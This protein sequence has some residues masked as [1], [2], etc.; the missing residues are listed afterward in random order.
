MAIPLRV[1]IVEDSENDTL[2]LVRELRSGGYDL[3]YER[4]DSL[5]GMKAALEKQGWDI[6][7][8]DYSMPDFRGTDALLLL[9]EK[10][11]DIPF[12]Y[13]SGTIGEDM[14]VAAMKAGANDYVLKDNL[15]RLVPAIRRELREAEGRQE[16]RRA[17]E[18]VRTAERKFRSLVESAPD[19]IVGVNKDGRIALLNAQTEQLFGYGRDELLNQPV[20]VLLPEVH[21]VSA[22]QS[23]DVG[24]VVDDHRRADGL[25]ERHHRRRSVE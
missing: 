11:T 24:A 13:V 2:L 6:V 22:A 12:I 16:R 19:G 25:P 18:A 14:A 9:R 17:E 23:G 8:S 3:T 1:L 15:K 10:D 4:V 5:E 21:A 7:L 20:E